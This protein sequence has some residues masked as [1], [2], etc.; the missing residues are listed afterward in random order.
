MVAFQKTYNLLIIFLI[1]HFQIRSYGFTSALGNFKV[2]LTD[3]ARA[4]I[5]FNMLR[6]SF[7]VQ[8]L[9]CNQT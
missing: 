2:A 1:A 3:M 9:V 5:L 8:C 7:Q 6:I 4:L